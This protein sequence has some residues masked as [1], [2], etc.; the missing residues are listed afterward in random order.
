[1]ETLRGVRDASRRA[2]TNPNSA[3][4]PPASST[5]RHAN[6]YVPRRSVRQREVSPPFAPDDPGGSA[7]FSAVTERRA[8]AQRACGAGRIGRV[9]SRVARRCPLSHGGSPGGRSK[10]RCVGGHGHGHRRAGRAR[11]PGRGRSGSTPH[12]G[13]G[14][15]FHRRRERST[16]IAMAVGPGAWFWVADRARVRRGA[17]AYPELIAPPRGTG[18]AVTPGQAD[19]S[20]YRQIA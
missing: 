16:R 9:S 11:T 2:P 18:P 7:A 19:D 10:P 13:A 4:G 17:A 5:I 14:T 6:V 12:A 8:G 1:M 20:R 3:G 15:T